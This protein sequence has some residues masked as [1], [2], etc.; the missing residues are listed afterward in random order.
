M[1]FIFVYFLLKDNFTI[2]YLNDPNPVPLSDN[3]MHGIVIKKPN[4]KTLL[5]LASLITLPNPKT[6]SS[7]FLLLKTRWK[8]R[9][10]LYGCELLLF[11]LSANFIG[12]WIEKVLRTQNLKKDWKSENILWKLRTVD[13]VFYLESEFYWYLCFSFVSHVQ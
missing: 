6:G 4:S 2:M 11:P 3:G 7:Q 8:M 5:T 12:N 13:V 10:S 9:I 1:M